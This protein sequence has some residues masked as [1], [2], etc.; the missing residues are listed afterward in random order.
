VSK[1]EGADLK[2][3]RFMGHCVNGRHFQFL[4]RA[5]TIL[6]FRYLQLPK[7]GWKQ[8]MTLQTIESISCGLS[9]D[10]LNPKIGCQMAGK[11]VKI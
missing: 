10:M 6:L 2:N 4:L 9:N 7:E 1:F 8:K 5:F 3:V 11:I